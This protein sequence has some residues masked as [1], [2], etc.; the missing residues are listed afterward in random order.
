MEK[1]FKLSEVLIG[2]SGYDYPEWKGAFYPEELRRSD[3]L[4]F[5]ATRFNALELNN[6]FYNMPTAE[7]MIS[8]YER[9]GGRIFFSVKANRFLTHELGRA[10]DSFAEEFRGAL[11]PLLKKGRLSSVLF[12]FPQGFHY[13]DVNRVYLAKLI[14]SFE[15]FPVVVEFRH[16]E[17]IRESVFEGLSLRKASLAFCDMPRLKALPCADFSGGLCSQFVGPFAYIRLHGRNANAWYASDADATSANGSAR[18]EYEYSDKE[19]GEFV[20]VIKVAAAEGKKVQVYFNNHP[21][22]HGARNALRLRELV[23]GVDSL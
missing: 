6:T 4:S 16:R 3:F 15:G 23:Q 20:P 9:S 21:K 17:W 22:G 2:T 13:T 14:E 11:E 18:Y 8:F 10:W 1:V 7:R 12:Q 19:L 5:Y